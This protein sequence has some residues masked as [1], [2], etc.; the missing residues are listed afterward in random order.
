MCLKTIWTHSPLTLH[1]C[2]TVTFNLHTALHQRRPSRH[3]PG[4]PAASFIPL[5]AYA[6]LEPDPSSPG[7]QPRTA[8]QKHVWTPAFPR[9]PLHQGQNGP[10]VLF[11]PLLRPLV[12]T[13]H[14]S[15]SQKAF[16]RISPRVARPP[17][18]QGQKQGEG[19]QSQIC[20]LRWSLSITASR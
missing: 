13:L 4:P 18:F 8:P 3:C 19:R 2:T 11:Y 16:R 5:D 14:S 7:G 17:R 6:C 15:R 9:A 1:T 10:A 20:P 12:Q